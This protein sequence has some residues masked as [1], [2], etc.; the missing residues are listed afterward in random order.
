MSVACW[1]QS[2]GECEQAVASDKATRKVYRSCNAQGAGKP[3]A[4]VCVMERCMVSMMMMM[5]MMMQDDAD[6]GGDDGCGEVVTWRPN[7]RHRH[8]QAIWATSQS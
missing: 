4:V 1:S 3:G 7:T 6:D 5:M 8:H 2:M